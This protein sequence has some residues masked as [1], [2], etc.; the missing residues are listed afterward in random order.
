MCN[1]C[2]DTRTRNTNAPIVFRERLGEGGEEYRDFSRKCR[3]KT[4]ME[5]IQVDKVKVMRYVLKK[6]YACYYIKIIPCIR[7]IPFNGHERK[8]KKK[9]KKKKRKKGKKKRIF[10]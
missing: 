2:D 6:A 1:A 8:L 4:I 3:N 9:R 5:T 7:I 10:V